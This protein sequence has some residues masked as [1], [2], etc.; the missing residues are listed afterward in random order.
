LAVSL[1]LSQFAV[2]RLS[3][4]WSALKPEILAQNAQLT[5]LFSPLNNFK[6]LRVLEDQPAAPA[7]KAPGN[8]LLF[9][10]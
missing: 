9:V 6:S 2:T 8:F 7:I 5:A 10:A 4:T 3:H 1:G